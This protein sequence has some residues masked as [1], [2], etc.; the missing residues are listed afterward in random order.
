MQIVKATASYEQWLRNQLRVIDSDLERKHRA[1]AD[2]LFS[3]LRATFYRWIQVWPEVCS[4]YA[5]APEVLAVGD[6]HVENFGTWRDVEGRLV[7]GINDFDEA[8][9]LPYTAD[10]IRLAVSA[11]LA[12]RGEHLRIGPKDACDAILAGYRKGLDTGGTAF[13]LEEHH[14]WLRSMVSGVL[15]DPPHFWG[16][17]DRLPT[18]QHCPSSALRAI[19]RLLPASGLSYRI[20]HRI[21]GLG[22]LGR[23][24]YVGIAECH[25]GKIARE[26]KALAPSA[27]VW[28]RGARA[29]AIWYDE[30]VDRAVRSADPFVRVK[31]RWIV[32]RLAPD[33]SRVE[34]ASMPKARDESRLLQ[35]M[36]FETANVHLGKRKI[37]TSILNDLRKR[38]RL[39]LHR[40]ALDMAEATTRDWERWRAHWSRGKKGVPDLQRATEPR[41]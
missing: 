35:S 31:G 4:V 27:S 16:K 13:V 20:V 8:C 28:T 32:R 9:S 30:I 12:I 37:A 24:R 14:H 29:R 21:A 23:E 25:G 22:S 15:R 41:R 19:E 26:A 17:L 33:C 1:M 11:H 10:L 18:E 3:F 34:L 39:W 36:G 6:L 7:W 38:P 40:A 5:S 2:D